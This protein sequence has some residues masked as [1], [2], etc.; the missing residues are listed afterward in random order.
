MTT[1]WD[2]EE[3]DLNAYLDRVGYT[4]ERTA[5]TAALHE[6]HRRHVTTIP[7]ENLE[8]QLGRPITLD[9][10]S[11]QRK[12]V[13]R[14]RGGY[15]FEHVTLFAAVL[16]RFGFGVEAL[17]SRVRYGQPAGAVLPET[18]ALLRVTV[19][20]TG[21]SWLCD[22]GFGFTALAPAEFVD[23][24]EVS[25]G[26]WHFR[27]VREG[28]YWLWQELAG[29]KVRD[30]H[31]TADLPRHPVDYQV[32]SHYVSTWPRSPFVTRPYAQRLGDGVRYQ[33]D[34]LELRTIR[35][36]EPEEARHLTPEELP[37]VL[38]TLFDIRLEA[39]DRAALIT[40]AAQLAEP[41]DSRAA[42]APRR[43]AA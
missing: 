42:G 5:S 39:P 19:P 8:I 20:G 11:L 15:C 38:D 27:L 32:N 9:L 4:G 24:A 6:L 17:V 7:F 34:G 12:L 18:H 43:A 40:R 35:P 25:A 41:D 1:T 13:Q 30:A 26:G 23:G 2:S 10:P 28:R 37:E 21:K 3:L 16:Q 36:G 33:L 14:R 31:I 22:V 29:G